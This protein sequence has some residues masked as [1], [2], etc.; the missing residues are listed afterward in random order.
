MVSVPVADYGYCGAGSDYVVSDVVDVDY[1]D[2]AAAAESV[3]L[4]SEWVS[5]AYGW[6]CDAVYDGSE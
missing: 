2:A 5:E 4:Y 6:W 1:V 3:D